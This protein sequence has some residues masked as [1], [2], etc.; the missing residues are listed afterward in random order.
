MTDELKYDYTHF[1][2]QL[3][4]LYGESK[5]GKSTLILD[6]LYHLNK[7]VEQIIVFAPTD[8]SNYT[9]QGGVVP[10][11]CIHYT[12]S[13]EVLTDIYKRQEAFAT[14]YKMVNNPKLLDRIL[15]RTGDAKIGQIL[16]AAETTFKSVIAEVGDA[17]GKDNIITSIEAKYMRFVE[18][19]KKRCIESHYDKL[20]A[21][22]LSTEERLALKYLHFNP[23]MVVVFDDCTE[24]LDKIKKDPIIQQYAFQ[25]RHQLITTIIAIHTDKNLDPA[26]KKQAMNSIFTEESCA[27]AYIDR[28]SNNFS[29]E[30]KKVAIDA[31]KSAFTPLAKHQK[32]MYVREHKKYYRITAIPRPGFVFES[33][34]LWDFC[35]YIRPEKAITGN[36]KIL[37]AMMSIK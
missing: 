7:L 33:P 12:V 23:R 5:T 31:L 25:A 6:I 27:M 19:C 16:K 17:P 1:L 34:F 32:L 4:V 18:M 9:Y 21:M 22:D 35:E 24:Q 28:A 20:S 26:F 13:V 36:N 10:L 11:A 8:K 15:A 37:A 3:T 14:I 29:R 30:A 2:D